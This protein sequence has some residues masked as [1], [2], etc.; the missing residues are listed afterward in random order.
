MELCRICAVV[1]RLCPSVRVVTIK[2]RDARHPNSDSVGSVQD[3]LGKGPGGREGG[4][5]RKVG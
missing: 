4:E 5:G 1:L 3:L 2:L